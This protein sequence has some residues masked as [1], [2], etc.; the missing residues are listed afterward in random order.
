MWSPAVAHR[1]LP[2]AGSSVTCWSLT[3]WEMSVQEGGCPIE[4]YVAFFED[5]CVALE[6]VRHTRRHLE[7][8]CNVIFCSFGGEPSCVTEENLV[9]TTLDQQGGK[10]ME[11]CEYGTDEWVRGIGTGHVG[12]NPH[13][14]YLRREEWIDFLLVV[15]GAA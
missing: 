11:V 1:A 4:R 12:T 2:V 5:G 6:H 9:G 13:A 3:V 15:N 14:K 8:D 7:F 10:S